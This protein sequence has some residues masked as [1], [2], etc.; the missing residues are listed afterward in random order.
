MAELATVFG[1]LVCLFSLFAIIF[2][3]KLLLGGTGHHDNDSP[4]VH[5]LRRAH[6]SRHRLCAGCRVNTFSPHATDCLELCSSPEE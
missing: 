2:P 1:S 4:A 5:R 3:N 6:T